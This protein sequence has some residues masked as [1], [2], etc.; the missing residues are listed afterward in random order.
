MRIKTHVTVIL[1]FIPGKTRLRSRK[2]ATVVLIYTN[3]IEIKI[4]QKIQLCIKYAKTK[5]KEKD[6][7]L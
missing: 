6:M 7:P 2:S 3:K 4:L 5:R 1:L